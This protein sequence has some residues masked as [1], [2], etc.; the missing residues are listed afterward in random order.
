MLTAIKLLLGLWTDWC[1]VKTSPFLCIFIIGIC[2]CNGCGSGERSMHAEKNK[3]CMKVFFSFFAGF[4]QLRATVF[5]QTSC[6]K[7][8]GTY[9][10][11]KFEN[12]SV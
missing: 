1:F 6:F 4:L 10:V 7:L 12:L 11:H 8:D 3:Y 2:L 9:F 5:L